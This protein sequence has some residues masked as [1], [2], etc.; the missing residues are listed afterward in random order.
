MPLY[1]VRSNVTAAQGHSVGGSIGHGLKFGVYVRSLEGP[2]TESPWPCHRLNQEPIG[3][4]HP[5]SGLGDGTGA[6]EARSEAAPRAAADDGYADD[7]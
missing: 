7:A 3:V 2:G 1:G 5:A 6:P 4:D